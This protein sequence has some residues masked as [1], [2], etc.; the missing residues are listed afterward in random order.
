MR[1]CIHLLNKSIL[2]TTRCG[3]GSEER[4]I[5]NL[6]VRCAVSKRT[7]V[8]LAADTVKIENSRDPRN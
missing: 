4:K 6:I 3:K 7:A 2:V 1:V 5:F 8:S